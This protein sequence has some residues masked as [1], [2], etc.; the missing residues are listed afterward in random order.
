M[1]VTGAAVDADGQIS[2]AQAHLAA[3]QAAVAPPVADP[4]HLRT[5]DSLFKLVC[6]QPKPGVRQPPVGPGEPEEKEKLVAVPRDQWYV[7]P[8][9]V[10]DNLYY[11]GTQTESTWALTTSA[12][13]SCS[14]PIFRG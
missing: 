12:G 11:I 9:K 3:A 14:T 8:V 6:T 10:F 1:L 13:S 7:P 2:A 4:H 5:Y